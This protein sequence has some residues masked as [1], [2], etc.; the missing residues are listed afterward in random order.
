M[1]ITG[2][3]ARGRKLMT[4]ASGKADIRPTSDRVR[5]ALFNILAQRTAGSTVLDLFAG[6]GA[7]GIEALSR[8]AAFVLFVDKSRQAGQLI[9]ANLRS[10][11]R[12][13]QA[14]F[15]CQDLA[16]PSKGLEKV[17]TLS[18]IPPFNLVFMDPPYT[19]KLAAPLLTNMEKTALLAPGALVVIEEHRNTRLP[20][21]AGTLKL[22]N[23][24]CY[25]ETGLWFYEL[26]NL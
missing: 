7:L 8:D 23:Q 24:R 12:Q 13:P 26:L 5:E 22:I 14:A 18:G 4:P 3:N 19:K 11:F 17:L 9:E 25:G 10:C 1:R 21:T 20:A 2:G 15:L 16:L 6:T